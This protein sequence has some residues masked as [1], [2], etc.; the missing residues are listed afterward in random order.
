MFFHQRIFPDNEDPL[1]SGI[2]ADKTQPMDDGFSTAVVTWT[3]PTASDNSG[4]VTLTSSHNPGDTFTLGVTTVTY[5][6]VDSDSNQMTESFT[7]TIEGK[8]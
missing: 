5:T 6:A 8:Y 2:P 7:V 3:P 4:V 1:I